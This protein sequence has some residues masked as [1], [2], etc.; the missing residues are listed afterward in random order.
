MW[1]W[2]HVACVQEHFI[3][4][5]LI[6]LFLVHEMKTGVQANMKNLFTTQLRWLQMESFKM[7]VA[8]L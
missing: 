2:N 7:N 6:R 1:R 4:L 8:S 5:R 3:G